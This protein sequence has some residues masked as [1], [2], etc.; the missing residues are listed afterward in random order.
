MTKKYITI[1][2]R[3]FSIVEVMVASLI[4][5]I[6]IEAAYLFFPI[7]NQ[8][9]RQGEALNEISQD[10]RIMLSRVNRDFRQTPNIITNIPEGRN[11]GVETIDMVDGF[12][13]EDDTNPHYIRYQK[14]SANFELVSIHYTDPNSPTTIVSHSF[15]DAVEEIE[16]TEKIVEN[17][18]NIKIYTEDDIVK[19]YLKMIKR[20]EDITLLTGVYPRNA[21]P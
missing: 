16:S 9:S 15:P 18:N 2:K 11:N 4:G 5:V 6:V 21:Q 7:G 10:A 14:T 3:G 8:I 12:R 19:I 13:E 17:L 1:K 20:G